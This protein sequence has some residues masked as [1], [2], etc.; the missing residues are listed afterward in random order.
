MTQQLTYPP[1]PIMP[2]VVGPTDGEHYAFLNNAA[3]VKVASDGHRSMSVVQF[4]APEGFAPPLHIHRAED[5]LFVVLDGEIVLFDGPTTHA[6]PKGTIAHLPSGRPHSFLVVTETARILNVTAV[7]AAH[8]QFDEMVVALG[9]SI[10]SPAIPQPQPIDPAVVA[11][12]CE[13]HGIDIVG[14]PPTQS[15]EQRKEG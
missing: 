11:Q 14:P 7:P 12:V 4:E 15:N 6:A 2:S 10:D 13:A 8:L 3:T 5:E 1:D 9:S